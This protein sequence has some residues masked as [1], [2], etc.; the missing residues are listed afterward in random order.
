[1]DTP[2]TTEKAILK[3][4]SSQGKADVSADIM[5]HDWAVYLCRN[6]GL[7]CDYWPRSGLYTFA[8]GTPYKVTTHP[9]TEG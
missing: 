3:T 4:V 5:N 8:T 9:L 1:M 7:K 2:E 6:N